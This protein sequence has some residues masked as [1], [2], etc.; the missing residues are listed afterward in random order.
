MEEYE[1][2]KL[3]EK[4]A[5]KFSPAG[6]GPI[7]VVMIILCLSSCQAFLHGRMNN[8]LR[9]RLASETTRCYN[10]RQVAVHSDLSIG[11]SPG[12]SWNPHCMTAMI[13]KDED[14]PAAAAH[15]LVT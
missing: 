7:L 3:T 8:I 1:V 12:P 15:Q 9:T 4:I 5:S 10:Y 13:G 14:N 11:K 6:R 2:T